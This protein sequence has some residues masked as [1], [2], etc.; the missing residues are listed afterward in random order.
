MTDETASVLREPTEG[1]T[2]S[3]DGPPQSAIAQVLRLGVCEEL[4][5]YLDDL[6]YEKL[7]FVRDDGGNW[8]VRTSTRQRGYTSLIW[9]GVESRAEDLT[10]YLDDICAEGSNAGSS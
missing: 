3:V 6:S 5:E 7:T 2:F 10:T 9:W 1:R 4:D 8:Y